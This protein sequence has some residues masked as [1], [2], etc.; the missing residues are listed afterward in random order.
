MNDQAGDLRARD[1]A[2]VLG[3]GNL[4]RYST[5]AARAITSTGP[6]RP[7]GSNEV[8]VRTLVVGPEISISG[9]ITSCQRVI[10]DG[11]L[12]ANLEG[13]QNLIIGETGVFRGGG[14]VE[15]ADVAGYFEG[16]LTVVGRLVIRATGR[17]SGTIRYNQIE[18]ECGGKILGTLDSL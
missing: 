15:N 11:T 10:V 16:D 17:V 7:P 8:D 13:C 9:E 2:D 5:E 12:H 4:S 14:R 6:K 1:V 18:I 3:L